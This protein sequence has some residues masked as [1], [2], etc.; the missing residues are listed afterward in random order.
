[1]IKECPEN[2]LIQ[3]DLEKVCNG[4][5]WKLA[6]ESLKG[7]DLLITGGTGLIGSQL[8]Y[9]LGVMNRLCDAG[10]NIYALVRD[11]KKALSVFGNM[12]ERGD[13]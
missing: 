7:K 12:A 13:L 1:M 5:L 3:E 8:I 4:Y 6:G 2:P 9:M 10:M 11:E